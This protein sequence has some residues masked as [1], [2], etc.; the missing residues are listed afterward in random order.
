MQTPYHI[1]HL[2]VQYEQYATESAYVAY[3]YDDEVLVNQA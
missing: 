1:Y 3:D 2:G